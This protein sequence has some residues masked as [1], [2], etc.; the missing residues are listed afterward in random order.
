MHNLKCSLLSNVVSNNPIQYFFIKTKFVDK[1]LEVL[2]DQQPPNQTS[3]GN[4][5]LFKLLNKQNK[6]TQ[7]HPKVEINTVSLTIGVNSRN[8]KGK[9]HRKA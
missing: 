2:I 1:F 6:V 8:K 4:F 9:K 3:A 5:A 7:P